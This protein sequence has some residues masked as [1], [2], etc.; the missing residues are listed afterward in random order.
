LALSIT[1]RY[2]TL[3]LLE[4]FGLTAGMAAGM[5]EDP[6]RTAAF[7]YHTITVLIAGIGV[8][9]LVCVISL[10]QTEPKAALKS[11]P[12]ADGVPGASPRTDWRS[13]FGLIG[14]MVVH[15]VLS[16]I[17]E[18]RLSPHGAF[19]DWTNQPYV[20]VDVT[21]FILCGF[22]AGRSIRTFVRRF[23][24][25]ALILFI[26]I[27]C[28]VL[29]DSDRHSDF[30]MFMD[31]LFSVFGHVVWVV[32]TAALIE[33]YA[34]KFWLYGL[35][36]VIYFTNVFLFIVPPLAR[37]IP[38]GPEYIVF[39]MGIAAAV[40]LLLSYR[41]IVPKK[42]HYVLAANSSSAADK[43]KNVNDFNAI[44]RERGLTT[45]EIEIAGLLARE[46][47]P[48]REI[49]KR[50]HVSTNTANTHIASIFRKFEVN[51]RAEFMALLLR[52]TPDKEG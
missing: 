23:L 11:E 7:L 52:G 10:R 12:E 46:G 17:M 20:F 47:L 21:A 37:L 43:T 24:P 42:P 28:L 6:L 27:P 30:L 38:A 49:A 36:I 8:F 1:A 5:A 14:I 22:L 35:A 29:F 25:P 45:R 26:F 2:C 15:K 9:T 31:I 13:I 50:L 16:G 40:F 18:W 48:A 34:G 33:L 39:S 4:A 32:F 44:F 51:K 3:R 19:M 41:I